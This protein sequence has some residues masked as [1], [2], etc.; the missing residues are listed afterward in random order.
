MPTKSASSSPSS[1]V[2]N[3]PRSDPGKQSY[4]FSLKDIQNDGILEC[5]QQNSD[6]V[7]HLE[8]IS[9]ILL[10]MQ[11]HANDDTY[12]TTKV[13]MAEAAEEAKKYNTKVINTGDPNVGR[14]GKVNGTSSA[15]VAKRPPSVLAKSTTSRYMNGKYTNSSASTTSQP[16]ASAVTPPLSITQPPTHDPELVR[17]Y[18]IHL[19]ALRPLKISDLLS[20]LQ[21]RLKDYVDK[22]TV[23]GVL[24]SIAMFKDSAYHLI[25]SYW[26]SEVQ[27]DWPHYSREE[28][29]QVALKRNGANSNGSNANSSISPGFDGGSYRGHVSSPGSST[30][31]PPLLSSKD[32]GASPYNR[33]GTLKRNIVNGGPV[34]P[35]TNGN[36]INKRIKADS[37]VPRNGNNS[38]PTSAMNGFGQAHISPLYNGKDGGGS[39]GRSSDNESTMS[40]SSDSG[41]SLYGD[42]SGNRNHSMGNGNHNPYPNYKLSIPTSYDHS[43]QKQHNGTSNGLYNNQRHNG[44]Y[45][46]HNGQSN[47]FNGHR[48]GNG[49]GSINST[50]N[51][52]P[53]SGISQLAGF[54]GSADSVINGHAT[55]PEEY[56]RCVPIVLKL[57][58]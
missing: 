14:K 2:H 12:A 6:N 35:T 30:T 27:L 38:R 33:N 23:V 49:S 41:S 40:N 43:N 1:S 22:N 58:G 52:S 54:G 55:Y 39:C 8:S 46:H 29:E 32:N 21:D 47:G 18:V 56:L 36:S 37:A 34:A 31:S 25:D 9:R 5:I 48:S 28:R 16:P 7:D 24:N 15:L 19:L 51:S 13:K 11:I 4:N 26:A 44:N 17:E 42:R 3:S 20:K 57:K 45:S 50:P 10:R 53:D